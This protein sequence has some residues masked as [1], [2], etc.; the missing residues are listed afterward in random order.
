[1]KITS[2][3]TWLTG[4][5]GVYLKI[6]TDEGISGYGEA[7]IPYFPQS[8][9]GML[10][11]LE[12]Y[13]IGEN[14]MRIEYIWQSLF[15][16]LFMRGGPTH[17]A[18]I[19]AID[20]ALYDLKGKALNVPV[21]ELLG[22]RVRDKI[23]LYGHVADPTLD[24]IVAKAKRLADTGCTMIRYRGFHAGDSRHEFDFAAGVDE[25]LQITSAMRE[26][27]GSKT[28]LIVECHGRYDLPWAVKLAKQLEK[29]DIY[30]MEDPLRQ[31]NP[32]MM[33]A[34]RRQTSVTLAT[35]ERC[36]SRWDFR[37]LFQ[38]NSIDYARP[39]VCHCGGI[40]E[41]IKI[42]SYA[43]T[44]GIS[45][46]PH[47]TQGP[48]AMAA[49]LHAAAAIDNISVVEA[50]FCNPENYDYTREKAAMG[51]PSCKDGYSPVPE[52]SGLG[53]EISEEVLDAAQNDFTP[54]KQ[55]R[56]R[57]YDGSVRDW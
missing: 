33:E 13:L 14:P 35:G 18:A 56:L 55:P 37:E 51:W 27:L 11:D 24:G 40:T 17:M 39:D 5:T 12:T 50:A 45:L 43:Q 29:Y 53:I 7:T 20:M 26:A 6:S 32:A 23:R 52:G 9:Y 48:L 25:Q 49:I 2:L 4:P 16:D 28:D 21:Y 15:R 31:E 10:K 34:L 19:S 3:K 57:A 38:N 8:V 22:G 42:A 41:M 44:Y 1:M 47:N 54:P 46:V 36:H 30:F